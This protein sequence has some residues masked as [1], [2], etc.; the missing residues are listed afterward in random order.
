VKKVILPMD[1]AANVCSILF[2]S[3][4]FIKNGFIGKKLMFILGYFRKNNI[5]G[6]KLETGE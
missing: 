2:S 6:D 4:I 5:C 3:K 1:T